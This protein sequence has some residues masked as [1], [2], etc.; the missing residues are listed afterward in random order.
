M[1]DPTTC[2]IRRQKTE[3]LSEVTE[4]ET[5]LSLATDKLG[6]LRRAIGTFLFTWT[7]HNPKSDVSFILNQLD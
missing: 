6:S 1:S 5:Q 3:Q 2:S 4:A 7:G